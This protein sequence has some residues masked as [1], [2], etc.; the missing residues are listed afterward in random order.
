MKYVYDITSGYVNF[1]CHFSNRTG[2]N[3]IP[4]EPHHMSIKNSSL[5]SHEAHVRIILR[6]NHYF[7]PLNE[8]NLSPPLVF[9][10]KIEIKN[11]HKS[12]PTPS[13]SFLNYSQHW[14][15]RTIEE[16]GKRWMKNF[17]PKFFLFLILKIK[18]RDKLER[19]KGE[20]TLSTLR[21][22]LTC[23]PHKDNIEF[24]IEMH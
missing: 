6:V 3:A 12:L 19:F 14:C 9:R 10:D 24:F 23:A 8:S 21:I 15:L 4:L 11:G 1:F 18:R 20:K 13:P 5:F 17:L 7:S 2:Q 16:E 22:V